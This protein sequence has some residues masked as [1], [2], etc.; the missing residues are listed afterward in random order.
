[1]G[2]SFLQLSLISISAPP[3]ELHPVEG[4]TEPRL[5]FA[6]LVIWGGPHIGL[7]RDIPFHPG[8][9]IIWSHHQPPDKC[10]KVVLSDSGQTSLVRLLRY[11][12]GEGQ[13]GTEAHEIR[14]RNAFPYGAVGAEIRVDGETWAIVREFCDAN[15]TMAE[16]NV[17][18]YDLLMKSQQT[19]LDSAGIEPFRKAML[20]AYG[21]DLPVHSK[22]SPDVALSVALSF[23]ARD[24]DGGFL[25]AHR[26]YAPHNNSGQRISKGD[27]VQGLCALLG[28]ENPEAIKHPPNPR[29]VNMASS[30]EEDATAKALIR[31]IAV[32]HKISNAESMDIP[33]LL[34]CLQEKASSQGR[35]S[36]ENKGWIRT[37]ENIRT[38]LQ[39]KRSNLNQE[40]LL[41]DERVK[42]LTE[43]AKVLEAEYGYLQM[44]MIEPDTKCLACDKKVSELLDSGCLMPK[45]GYDPVAMKEKLIAKEAQLTGCKF[46]LLEKRKHADKLKKNTKKTEMEICE[47]EKK[48][49]G[50]QKRLDG[51]SN[52]LTGIRSD[53]L[54]CE[55]YAE[56]WLAKS[57]QPPQ[58]PVQIDSDGDLLARLCASELALAKFDNAFKRVIGELESREAFGKVEVEAENLELHVHMDGEQS[59]SQANLI[60]LLAFD[61]A[62]LVRSMEAQIFAPGLLIHDSPRQADL[63]ED[64]YF[65]LF[66]LAKKLEALCQGNP[67]FQYIITTTTA[68]PEPFRLPPYVVLDLDAQ[69]RD[70][71]GLLFKQRF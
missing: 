57:D 3:L 52:I 8:L 71:S 59:G 50:H 17:S 6:R 66:N 15:A 26:G 62:V 36:D 16:R 56:A 33:E 69:S 13:F 41:L 18:L 24:H 20:A 53:I 19:K 63:S 34:R 35:K 45:V 32:R 7:I 14:V 37:E 40:L 30:P 5:W 12:L 64:Q 46:D 1:M 23:I 42:N 2:D 29:R 25:D 39:E 70:G 9:N 11:C 10:S 61:F 22:V 60:K 43:Q 49:D 47:I 44:H 28:F 67:L 58:P 55:R 68:P 38:Q 4:R 51:I 27:R 54:V 65:G 21:P 48:M 31:K